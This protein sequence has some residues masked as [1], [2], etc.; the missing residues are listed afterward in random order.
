MRVRI[1]ISVAS[2]FFL[3]GQLL[4][5]AEG[6][7]A[8]SIS[9][10]RQL[11]VDRSLIDRMDRVT[12]RLHEPIS[13]GVAIRIDKP[14]EGPGNCGISV[15]EI[16]GRLLL[17]YRALSLTD[18]DDVNGVSCVA[19]SRDGGAT[20][21]K[22]ALGLVKRPEWPANNVIATAEG[23]PRFSFPNAPW[24]DARPGVPAAERVKLV[25]SVPAE[26]NEKHTSIDYSG[27]LKRLVFYGSRDGFSFHKLEPQP[28]F[29]SDLKNVFDGN[30]TMFWSEAEQQY[31]V[32][33]RWYEGK[34]KEEMEG[35]PTGGGGWRTIARSTSKDL[36]TWTKPVPMTYGGSPRDHIYVN[37]TQPYFRAPH[38]Y[39]APAARF[40]ELRRAISRE[41]AESI[42]LRVKK[43]GWLEWDWSG[44][45]SD[46]VLLT[47]RAGS[48]VYDRTFLETFVRPGLGDA[49]WTSRSNYL[50]TGILPAGDEQIQ[51]YVS[52]RYLQDA[53]YIERMLLRTDGFASASAPWAGGELVTK[54]FTFTGRVLEIN[55]RT[56]APGFVRVEVQDG[57]GEP[58]PGYTLTECPEIIGDEI[59]REVAWENI[60]DLSRLAGQPVRLR[61][62]MKDAD[63]FSFRFRDGKKE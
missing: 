8:A 62:V 54:P 18:P 6:G 7:E 17:Y 33:F 37:N 1:H 28:D 58:I 5:M 42:G 63:L 48:T 49:H 44:E 22:P 53:W 38:L 59:T 55:Y 32:Y 2:G 20:W 29:I 23:E 24:V 56:G 41:R 19:E 51:M 16:E 34:M 26:G 3:L 25:Q 46:G 15:I 12:L 47:S 13:S 4:A 11:F 39:V 9:D 60:A 52:R 31:V 27:G 30:T 43:V 14:W 61:F 10:S 35:Q 36:M 50:L 40:M 57:K 21:I 45:C